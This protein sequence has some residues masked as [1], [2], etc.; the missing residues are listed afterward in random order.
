MLSATARRINAQLIG[1]DLEFQRVVTD[2]RQLRAGDLFVALKG[3]N[4][5]GHEFVQKAADAGAV[6]AIVSRP[7]TGALPKIVVK[8]TLQGLQQFAASWRKDFDLPVVAVT[9]SNG[10]TTTK[11]ML[12]AIFATRGSVLA[13][14]GNLNNH[15]G[16]PLTLLSLR[17][18]H[19]TAVIEMGANHHGEIALL[20]RLTAPDVG[21]I[22]QAGDAHLEGFGSREGVARGK[23]E[24]FSGMSAQ[25]VAVVNVDDAYA[26]L[27]KELCV[28]KSI[29][30]FG[31]AAKADVQA[32]HVEI[33]AD[34]CVFQLITPVGVEIVKLPLPGRH[35]ISNALGAAAC[36]VALGMDVEHIAEGLSR[37]EG[38]SGRVS[39]KTTAQGA[40]LLDDSYNANPSS[41]RAGMEL[42][43]AL[44]GERWLVLG[45]M[46][47]LGEDAAR[48]HYEAGATAKSLGIN[49]LFALGELAAEAA[50]AF[51]EGGSAYT[52]VDALA[53]DLRHCLNKNIAVLVKGSRS[54]R[55]ER[56][57]AE[58][59]EE[60]NIQVH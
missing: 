28:E 36:G 9:G 14:A 58:L 38:A 13:T 26:G 15:I 16:L 24:L 59:C 8:D 55:M 4:F 5:D 45:G 60:K 57:V 2:T 51:G 56:V 32:R 33:H 23:G 10:K 35:N 31:F 12:S 52:E 46:A 50:K 21:L 37:V 30:T 17:K 54:A 43:A 40:R 18:E 6:G 25:G 19:S 48:L 41:L 49:R 3:D 27:W 47:E 29:L 11:Q 44:P 20:T 1:S 39:W 22:T 7:V 34:H 53:Q 42:L